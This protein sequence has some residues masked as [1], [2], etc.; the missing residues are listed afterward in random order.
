[1]RTDGPLV[2]AEVRREVDLTGSAGG[3]S[4]CGISTSASSAKISRYR[5]S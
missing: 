5:S 3:A 4:G 2:D 1:M